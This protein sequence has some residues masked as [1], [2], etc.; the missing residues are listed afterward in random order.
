MQHANGRSALDGELRRVQ[1]S[2]GEVCAHVHFALVP[3]HNI[4]HCL[5]WAR[6]EFEGLFEKSPAEANAYLS[7]PDEYESNARA[8]ADASMLRNVEKISQCLILADARH[9]KSASTGRAYDFKNTSTI[10]SRN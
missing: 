7:K 6:S 3:S 8:N 10:E 2:P 4:D 1:R 5:T 9:F